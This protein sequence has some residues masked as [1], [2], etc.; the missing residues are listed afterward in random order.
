MKKT[1]LVM[2][3]LGW[4]SLIILPANAKTVI[5]EEV[6]SPSPTYVIVQEQPPADLVDERPATP[7]SNYIWLPGY[8]KFKDGR[9]HWKKGYWEVKPNPGATWVP[10]H[11][12]KKH[13]HG[14]VW[15]EG[16]WA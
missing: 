10:G 1:P 5:V 15:I 12:I 16:H 4:T 7:G 2:A 8:W 13:H 14:W 6:Q 11:W 9:W 3:L